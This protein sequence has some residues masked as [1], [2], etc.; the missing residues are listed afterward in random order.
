[1]L[2]RDAPVDFDDRVYGPTEMM[3]PFKECLF[4]N[5]ME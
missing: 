4:M 1:V 5:A 3:M 2:I